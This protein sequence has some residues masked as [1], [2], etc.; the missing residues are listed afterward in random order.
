[1]KRGM[2]ICCR[3]YAKKEKEIEE[4]CLSFENRA[5]SLEQENDSLRLALKIIV[6]E[7]NECDSRPQKAGECWSFVENSH[8][9]KSIKNKCNQQT[10]PNENIDASNRFEPL[11]NEV[12][13]S[14]INVS[15]TPSNEAS[16][17]R[18][19]RVPS[20]RCSQTSNSLTEQREPQ[21]VKRMIQQINRQRKRKCS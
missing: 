17:D 6:Q 14:L 20:A 18:R 16:E 8:A 21:T 19:N 11:R 9:A 1:M 7:R 13:G 2:D 10:I 15:P 3:H 5:L 12:Q 4:K